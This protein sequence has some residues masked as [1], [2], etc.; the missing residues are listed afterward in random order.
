MKNYGSLII[1]HLILSGAD[2]VVQKPNAGH[3]TKIKPLYFLKEG[4]GSYEKDNLIDCC[5]GCCVLFWW[6]LQLFCRY[7]FFG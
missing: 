6:P 5:C 1:S 2:C 4:R 3:Y 7:L